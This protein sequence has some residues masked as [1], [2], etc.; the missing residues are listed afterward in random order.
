MYTAGCKDIENLSLGQ[1]LNSFIIYFQQAK[2]RLW[3]HVIYCKKDVPDR[4]SRFDVY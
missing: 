3:L 1:R 4:L 2:N